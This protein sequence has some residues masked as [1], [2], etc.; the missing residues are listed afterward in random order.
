MDYTLLIEKYIQNRL[1]SEEEVLF[2]E[3]LKT[4][5]NFKDEVALHTK[6]KK[7]VKHEEDTNFRNLISEIESKSKSPSKKSS[8]KKWLVA[9][10]ILLISALGYI[11]LNKNTYTSQELFASYFEP[12][13]NVVHPIAR[14][15]EQQNDKAI[16][17]S[18][19]EKG[20]YNTAI[21][22]F[23]Q[24]YN[25]SK[26]PYYLFY[27][28]NALLKLEQADEAIPLLLEH[29]KTQDTLTKRT[30]WYLALAYLKT[31]D[32][33]KAKELLNTIISE[34]SYKNKEAKE[35]LDKFE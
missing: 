5:S 18:A 22:L 11:S 23:T 24:L 1:S 6:I 26:E 2:N 25:S 20:D 9:A 32:I 8:Y 31:E 33:Q 7:V 13:R 15:D 17:F 35:L 21:T 34:G 4:N 19:Y 30:N 3:L 10:S 28:A 29:L 12:Y 27:K 14:N 16:A